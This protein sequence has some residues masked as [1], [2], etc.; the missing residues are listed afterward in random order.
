MLGATMNL[1]HLA[2]V[3]DAAAACD[4]TPRSP[5]RVLSDRYITAA[6]HEFKTLTRSLS[7]AIGCFVFH[8]LNSSRVH[9]S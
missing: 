1:L 2:S 6:I 4:G 3:V 5:H 7:Q 9:V 8:A